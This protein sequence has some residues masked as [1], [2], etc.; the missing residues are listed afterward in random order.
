MFGQELGRWTSDGHW[1]GRPG[2][3][4]AWRRR[5]AGTQEQEVATKGRGWWVELTGESKLEEGW[6][7]AGMIFGMTYYFEGLR[8]EQ[9]QIMLENGGSP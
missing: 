5:I 9:C 8:E 4:L 1:Q 7:I 3:K 2:R 6:M